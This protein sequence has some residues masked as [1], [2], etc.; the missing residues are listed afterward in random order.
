VT[1]PPARAVLGALL[2]TT[3]GI[4]VHGSGRAC[5]GDITLPPS[6]FSASVSWRNLPTL[7]VQAHPLPLLVRHDRASVL[8]RPLAIVCKEDAEPRKHRHQLHAGQVGPL[9]A[10][11]PDDDPAEP[12][13]KGLLQSVHGRCI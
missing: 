3:V 9:T 13:L 4:I 12:G 8:G 5:C 7:Q 10:Q 11:D 1:A 2:H 6:Q